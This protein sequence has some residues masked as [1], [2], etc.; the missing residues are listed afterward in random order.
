MHHEFIPFIA[1]RS[2]VKWDEKKADKKIERW[3]KIAKEAAE[4]SHDNIIPE[5]ARPVAFTSTY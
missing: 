3:Q 2:I 5:V 4:Q 1:D